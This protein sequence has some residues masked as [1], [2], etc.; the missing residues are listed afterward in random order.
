MKKGMILL[1]L[2][3]ALSFTVYAGAK[4]ESGLKRYKIGFS[5]LQL[6]EEFHRVVW[7]S[8]KAAVE[9]RGDL[10]VGTDPG[11]DSARQVSQI[12]DMIA[13]K[14]DILILGPVSADGILPAL[15]A[16]KDAGIPVVN[17]DSPVKDQDL[18][19]TVIT[20]D[21]Y[22]AGQLAGNYFK[23]HVVN[24]GKV[25]LFNNPEV[26]GVNM[27]QKGFEDTVA[28]TGLTCAYYIYNGDPIGKSEDAITS[29][30]DA[31]GIFGTVSIFSTAAVASLEQRNLTSKIP[32]VSVDGSPEEKVYIK[33]GAILATVA[34]SPIGLG[35]TSV[36]YAY[37]ILAGETV[38]KT[39]KLKPFIIDKSNVDQYGLDRW[40]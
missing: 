27:R 3:L 24:T 29:N 17:Y 16:C 8:V 2:G 20:S 1:F 5:C 9:A 13:Q 33:N 12:E 23:Q 6:E 40:Q 36:D 14:I 39:E 11:G 7:D 31:V 37:K 32:I 28:G 30:P 15:I 38:P 25:I 34:Q 10:F 26:E 18:V 35:K 22:L 4:K 19:A 21:N